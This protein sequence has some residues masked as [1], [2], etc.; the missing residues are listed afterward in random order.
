MCSAKQTV[1]LFRLIS[2]SNSES[3]AAFGLGLDLMW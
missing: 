3:K 1:L 2:I